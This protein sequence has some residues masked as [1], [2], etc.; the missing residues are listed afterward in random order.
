M[1]IPFIVIA[2]A[3]LAGGALGIAAAKEVAHKKTKTTTTTREI[4]E[5]EVPED[6]R[7]KIEGKNSRLVNHGNV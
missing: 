4:S 5:S 1:P 3:A 7:R 2:G 6:I